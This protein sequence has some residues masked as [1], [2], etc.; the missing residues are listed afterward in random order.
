[1]AS[2]Q[3]ITKQTSKIIPASKGLLQNAV[4]GIGADKVMTTLDN[5]VGSPVQ[6]IA[7]ISLPFIGSVGPID[8]I[9]YV[10]HA[11]GFRFSC[12]FLEVSEGMGP[13]RLPGSG[14][15]PQSAGGSTP[16]SSAPGG[17]SF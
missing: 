1:M 12:V 11:G 14:I 5:L 9:N 13:I 15:S 10:G 2:L 16:T 17:A 6:R 3:S 4:T 8:F 7:S